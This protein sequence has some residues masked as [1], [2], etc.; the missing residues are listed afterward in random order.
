MGAPV[1]QHR[2]ARITRQLERQPG[3]ESQACPRM[4]GQLSVVGQKREVLRDE[5]QV[6]LGDLGRGPQPLDTRIE[7]PDNR[8]EIGRA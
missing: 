3:V 8:I 6:A 7:R 4:L 2:S 1:L 5:S